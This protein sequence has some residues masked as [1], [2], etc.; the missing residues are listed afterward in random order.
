MH[1]IHT[2]T[3]TYESVNQSHHAMCKHRPWTTPGYLTSRQPTN[4]TTAP[5]TILLRDPNDHRA[6][7]PTSL[8]LRA[9]LNSVQVSVFGPTDPVDKIEAKIMEAFSQ[10]GGHE[11]PNNGQFSAARFAFLFKVCA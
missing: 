11:P 7:L 1:C 3:Y 8:R 9:T 2:A 5:C 6:H 10:N 4:T